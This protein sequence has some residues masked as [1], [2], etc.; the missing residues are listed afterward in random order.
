M[1]QADL[2]ADGLGQDVD[3]GGHQKALQGRSGADRI[4]ALL[5]IERNSPGVSEGS[6]LGS[7]CASNCSHASSDGG[8]PSAPYSLAAGIASA[9]A[10]DLSASLSGDAKRLFASTKPNE[11]GVTALPK[12]RDEIAS[13][14]TTASA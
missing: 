3:G 8:A 10:R 7:V 6:W 5:K 4:G 13:A 11:A 12:T 1:I 14:V 9:K 2:A